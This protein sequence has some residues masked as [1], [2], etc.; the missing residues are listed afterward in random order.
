MHWNGILIIYKTV[1]LM[2]IIR[3][4]SSLVIYYRGFKKCCATDEGDRDAYASSISDPK[5]AGHGKE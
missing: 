5:L 2:S 4:P 3:N 1:M